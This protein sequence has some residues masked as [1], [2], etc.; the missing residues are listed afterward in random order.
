MA[1]S[2]K[3]LSPEND[4]KMGRRPDKMQSS[5]LT[6]AAR[7]HCSAVDMT[8][9]IALLRA[10]NVGGNNTLP[11]TELK[12]LCEAAGF[13]KVRTYIA[14]GNVVFESKASEAKVKA[15]LEAKI[16]THT[17]AKIGVI[18]RTAAE[19][20]AVLERNPFAEKPP[21]KTVAIFL[22]AA[23]ARGALE[24][25]TG[26][27]DEEVRLGA[28]EIY[29]HYPSGQGRSKLKIPAARDGTARNMNT[30]AALTKLASS[31]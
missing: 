29:T 30:L 19:M 25:M 6:V 4:H 14:S 2:L 12:A 16:A 1:I 24:A 27:K 7:I 11:M 28:R 17:G 9:F 18:V 15:A 20:A 5:Q 31:L 8:A 21:S 22:D 13:G 10:V 23:P 26:R 3:E